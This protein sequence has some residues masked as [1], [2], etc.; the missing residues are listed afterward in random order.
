MK[1]RIASSIVLFSFLLFFFGSSAFA[2]KTKNFINHEKQML[3][4]GEDFKILGEVTLKPGEEKSFQTY[5]YK[6]VTID[7]KTSVSKGKAKR[8]KNSG[9]GIKKTTSLKYYLKDP[10]GASMDILPNGGSVKVSLKNFE[11]FPIKVKVYK[12]IEKI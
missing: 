3:L 10:Q 6:P 9:I 5:S 4:K 8:C 11:K 12:I 1:L 7:F 2:M